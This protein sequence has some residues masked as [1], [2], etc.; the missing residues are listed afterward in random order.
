MTKTMCNCLRASCARQYCEA[1]PCHRS[2]R[3]LP[4]GPSARCERASPYTR[5][6]LRPRISPSETTVRSAR[7]AYFRWWPVRATNSSMI[8]RFSSVD[9]FRY[10]SETA[11][12][13]SRRKAAL[14]VAIWRPLSAPAGAANFVRQRSPSGS[15]RLF[16]PGSPVF[17][18]TRSRHRGLISAESTDDGGD[19]GY[20]PGGRLGICPGGERSPSLVSCGRIGELNVSTNELPPICGRTRSANLDLDHLRA[21]FVDL[22]QSA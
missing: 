2:G 1:W 18:L 7:T 22:G 9:P 5:D 14:T 6:R 19:N 17:P 13:N 20:D 8:R 12:N 21:S 11:S 16:T 10:I 4:T 3:T 15:K